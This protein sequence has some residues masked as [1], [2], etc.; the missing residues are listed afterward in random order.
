MSSPGPRRDPTL[1]LFLALWPDPAARRALAAWMAGWQW[2]ARAR[3]VPPEQ[4]HLTLHFLGPVP[5]SRLPALTQGLAVAAE[6]VELELG[7]VAR[8]AGGLVVLE[9]K[10]VPAALAQLHDGLAQALEALALPLERSAYRPHVTLARKA[11]GALAPPAPLDLRW[12]SA[13]Y[14]LVQS[15]GGYHDLARYAALQRQSRL[16]PPDDC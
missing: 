1:R 9:P 11:G 12:R 15:Q 2:P 4:L 13:G 10:R 6:P 16:P 7:T 14:A 5:A 3:I 8:W